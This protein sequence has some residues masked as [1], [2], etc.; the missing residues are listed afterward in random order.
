MAKEIT[1]KMSLE[2]LAEIGASGLQVRVSHE[3]I[4]KAMGFRARMA[5]HQNP[6]EFVNNMYGSHPDES[7]THYFDAVYNLAK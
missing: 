7:G 2:T 6:V 3:E 4:Q 5:D 1:V